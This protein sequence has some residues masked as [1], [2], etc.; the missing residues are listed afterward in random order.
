[1]D[2]LDP[3]LVSP[4]G[5]PV[6]KTDNLYIRKRTRLHEYEV[7][8]VGFEDTTWNTG[9]KYPCSTW[10]FMSIYTTG[11]INNRNVQQD[12]LSAIDS[13]CEVRFNDNERYAVRGEVTNIPLVHKQWFRLFM[14]TNAS[15]PA[16]HDHHCGYGDL[17]VLL[18]NYPYEWNMKKHNPNFCGHTDV[19]IQ[20]Q[21]AY[22][23]LGVQRPI[24]TDTTLLYYIPHGYEY[25]HLCATSTMK[26]FTIQVDQ[27]MNSRCPNDTAEVICSALYDGTDL[28][29]CVSFFLCTDRVRLI[30]KNLDSEDDE[31]LFHGFFVAKA[32]NR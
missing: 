17:I 21:M 15:Q 24:G 12:Q 22:Y 20:N 8:R 27:Y 30:V 6:F 25:L 26:N 2:R 23:W 3:R 10:D 19:L 29:T 9:T 14:E 16:T 4:S 31:I 32:D 28:S 5:M 1:M 7:I 13:V 11:A 18:H